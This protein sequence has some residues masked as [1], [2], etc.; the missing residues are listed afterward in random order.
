MGTWAAVAADGVA[1]AL[2][3]AAACALNGLV[4]ANTEAAAMTGTLQRLSYGFK[5]ASLRWVRAGDGCP[6]RPTVPT[7]TVGVTGAT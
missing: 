2:G 7:G 5:S 1:G 3:E 4:S 6:R